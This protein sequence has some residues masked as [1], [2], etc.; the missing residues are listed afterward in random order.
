VPGWEQKQPLCPP[1]GVGAGVGAEAASLS[2]AGA[3]K[4]VG[5]E[6]ASL[7]IARAGAGV[8]AEAASLSTAGVGLGVAAE[9]AFLS[10]AMKQ[11]YVEFLLA[12]TPT[13]LS[14]LIRPC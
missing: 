9:A 5:A 1:A 14:S 3:G 8:G 10:I 7:S 11:F 4:G 2:I 12:S 13:A 6:A